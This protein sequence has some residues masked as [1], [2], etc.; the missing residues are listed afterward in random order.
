MTAQTRVVSVFCAFF[1]PSAGG[2]LPTCSPGP[3]FCPDTPQEDGT[4]KT[5][6]PG[7]IPPVPFFFKVRCPSLTAVFPGSPARA[8]LCIPGPASG[9][10]DG[11]QS[12]SPLPCRAPSVTGRGSAPWQRRSTQGDAMP[13]LSRMAMPCRDEEAIFLNVDIGTGEPSSFP[14][15][16]IH[17]F[18]LCFPALC[19]AFS[20]ADSAL[21]PLGAARPLPAFRSFASPDEKF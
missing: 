13:Q 21:P 14:P 10:K 15:G 1:R 18:F 6:S 9:L 20:V 19:R 12:F 5:L 11:G 16:L 4:E 3:D 8:A 17:R 7:R 2:V